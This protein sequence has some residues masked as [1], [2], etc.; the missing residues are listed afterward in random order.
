M[1]S[2]IIPTFNRANF[3]AHAINSVINQ[4]YSQFELLIIDDGSTD[5]TR[6]VIN[7]FKDDRIKYIY[8]ENAER[9]A[10]RNKG[11]SLASFEWICFLDSDDIFLPNH[12]ETFFQAINTNNT[13]RLILSGIS[14]KNQGGITNHPFI[15][16]NPDYVLKEI[17]NKFILINTVCVNHKILSSNKFDEKYSIWEDTHLWL[18][19][20]AKFK[21]QQIKSL[22]TLQIIHSESSVV[23]QFNYVKLAKAKEYLNAILDLRDNYK[24]VFEKKISR[25]EFT[26]YYIE[27]NKM[28]LHTSR[29]NKQVRTSLYLSYL[30]IKKEPSLYTLKEF[31]K[32]F[33]N[34]LGVGIHAQ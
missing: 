2:V 21:V 18:R 8:Q 28:L 32:I 34:K 27:K 12:L 4:S 10:A 15:E 23:Q 14:I 33:L 5:N 26:E 19:I 29:Q 11:I 30:L 9:S 20:A 7:Q 13:P 1:F 6:E 24:D 25:Q 31:F 3:I 17:M 16:T 22:T